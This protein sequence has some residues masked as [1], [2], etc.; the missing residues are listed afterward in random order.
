ME[1]VILLRY[2]IS[3]RFLKSVRMF[4]KSSAKIAAILIFISFFFSFVSAQETDGDSSRQSRKVRTVTIPVSI[5]T[6]QE[7]KENQN[8]EFIEAGNIVVKE[9]NEPQVVLSIRSVGSS[10]PLA[11]AVLIQDDLTANVN[12][13]LASLR[14]F[15]LNLPRGSRV[16]VGYLRSGSMQTR[17]K[18]T[19]DLTRAAKSVRIVVGSSTLAPSNPYEQLDDA[20]KRFDALPTGRQ[21]VLLISDGLDISRGVESSSPSQS[22]DLD[23]AIARAQRKGVAVYSFYNAGSYT[24]NANSMLV[25]NG[26][27]SLNRLS[28]ETGGRAFFQG[29]TSPISFD[30]FFRDLNAALNRQFALTYLS[31]HFKKGYHKI[32]V[33]STNPAVKIE[34]PKGYFYR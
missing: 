19:D 28:D 5:F 10:A 33:S 3:F 25:L 4:N 26:Q 7:L 21:A 24:D 31:T 6:K 13:Q 34:H 14:K 12:L 17:Q 23:R 22:I 11:L 32:D 16:M 8:E 9:D 2:E 20:L 27:G 1:N 18:F 15:I 30:P 29:S